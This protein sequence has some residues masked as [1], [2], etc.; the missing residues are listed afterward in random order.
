MGRAGARVDVR[1]GEI[2]GQ[3]GT[4]CGIDRARHDQRCKFCRKFTAEHNCNPDLARSLDTEGALVD[5]TVIIP[6]WGCNGF[7]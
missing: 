4:L 7:F 2:G 5:P 3:Q 6:S 1:L